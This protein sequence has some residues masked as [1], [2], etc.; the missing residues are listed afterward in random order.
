MDFI[1]IKKRLAIILSAIMAIT[2]LIAIA[3]IFVLCVNAFW[4]AGG[5]FTNGNWIIAIIEWVGLIAGGLLIIALDYRI[6]MGFHWLM[7]KI[8]DVD[9]TA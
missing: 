6:Y 8:L 2:V 5:S 1:K 3:L 9:K 4:E 7:K